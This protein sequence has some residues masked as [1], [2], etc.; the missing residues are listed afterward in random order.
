MRKREARIPGEHV[1]LELREI[2]EQV[3]SSGRVDGHGLKV[4][5]EV[6]YADGLIDR[7]EADFLVMIHKRTRHRTQ[8]FEQFFYNAIKKH[9]LQ[10]GEIDAEETAW[11]REM[12]LSDHN[13]EDEERKFLHELRGEAARVSPEFLALYDESMKL[14]PE[15]H[16]S[17]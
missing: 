8:S 2:E 4:L 7:E 3:I 10:D 13:L 12:L 14:P 1:M 11:L 15:Q 17:G 9:I 6:L 16:T 5:R